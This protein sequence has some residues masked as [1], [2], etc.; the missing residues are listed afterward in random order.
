M[1]ARGGRRTDRELAQTRERVETLLLQSLRPAAIHRALTGPD[2]PSPLTLSVDAVE[3]HCRAVEASWR[4]RNTDIEATRARL[5][6]LAEETMRVASQR[7]TMNARSNIGVG[8]FNAFIKAQE[9]VARLSG[10]DA[11][12]RQELTGKGG[13]PIQVEPIALTDHPAEHLDRL[14]EA[15]R[16]HQMAADYEAEIADTMAPS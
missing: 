1:T 13:R 10:A 4:D 12:M 3:R 16:L 7:S 9:R 14:E 2:N 15:R 6:A 11:P 5:L 8:Y